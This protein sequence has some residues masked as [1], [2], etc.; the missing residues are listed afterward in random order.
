MFLNFFDVL[1][2]KIF[3]LCIS[4]KNTLKSNRYHNDQHQP[5]FLKKYF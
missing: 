3:F 5:V 1:L 2:L 4:E